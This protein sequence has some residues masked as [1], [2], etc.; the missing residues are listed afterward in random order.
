MTRMQK[1]AELAKEVSRAVR[2]IMAE[3]D[4]TQRDV[5]SEAKVTLSVIN[6]AYHGTA[7]PSPDALVRIADRYNV[8]VDWLLGRDAPKKRTTRKS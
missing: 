1:T 7:T 8:T 2:Q 3:L 6:R 4:L 5:A